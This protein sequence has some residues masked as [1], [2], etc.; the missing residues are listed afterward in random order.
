MC[1]FNHAETLQ[2]RFR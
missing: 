1:F 2:E